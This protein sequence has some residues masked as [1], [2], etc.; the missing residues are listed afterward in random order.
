[1]SQGYGPAAFVINDLC[2]GAIY[3]QRLRHDGPIM[4]HLR[5]KGVDAVALLEDVD[6]LQ[7]ERCQQHQH[8]N[9]KA[10]HHYTIHRR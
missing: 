10:T 3:H 9:G 1:M 4:G 5:L 6:A 8:H 2:Q 7:A